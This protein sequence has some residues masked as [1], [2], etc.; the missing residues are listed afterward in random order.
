MK[1]PGG[2]CF[3]Q[4]LLLIVPKNSGIQNVY[5][6][7]IRAIE[8]AKRLKPPL[9]EYVIAI[10]EAYYK[11]M[12]A[13]SSENGAF[14]RELTT[15]R[16]SGPIGTNVGPPVIPLDEYM[17]GKELTKNNPKEKK[18]GIMGF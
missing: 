14:A 2:S 16:V 9:R 8:S 13:I 11:G 12:L 15:S 6:D 17:Y 5:P 3:I 1:M 7:T 10:A 4:P 18:W